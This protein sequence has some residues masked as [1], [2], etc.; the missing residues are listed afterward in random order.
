MATITR[1][2][3]APAAAKGKFDGEFDVIVVG[4][5]VA[6]LATAL[7]SRWHGNKVLVLEKASS[8]AA[9]RERR[10]S[11]TGC[12]TT[13][14]CGRSA[15]RTQGGLHPLHGAAV[16]PGNLQR[17]CAAVRHA[18][19]GIFAVRGDLR[20]RL[21]GD[22]IAQPR[23]ARSNTATATSCPTIG[24]SCPR[25][26]RRKAACCCPRTRARRCP[27]AAR[28]RSR[29]CRRPPSATAS[30]S[31]PAIACSASIVER[32]G[33]NHRRRGRHRQGQDGRFLARKAVVFCT[34]GFTHD[35]ELR[36]NYLS[37]PVYGGCAALEQRG[38]LRL[39]RP[40]PSA[41]NCAT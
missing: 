31:A 4:G 41:R 30:I 1:K 11:G 25:T 19:M 13:S 21:D 12:R 14:A 26:R 7:F 29:R 5:G 32:Q 6:G 23:R 20:Q 22:G 18:P 38:R 3:A 27:T 37:A 36:K 9:R 2:S 16:A 10:P 15:S 35:V 40:A 39:H 24:P 8:S 33:R 17:R 34:G 28:W